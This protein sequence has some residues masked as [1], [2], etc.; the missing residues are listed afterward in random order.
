[1]DASQAPRTLPST[2]YVP[3][4]VVDWKLRLRNMS[5]THMSWEW[6]R[7]ELNPDLLASK[8]KPEAAK[9]VWRIM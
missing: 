8:P 4:R 3:N 7:W 2:E 9:T 6:K 5:K 1:M